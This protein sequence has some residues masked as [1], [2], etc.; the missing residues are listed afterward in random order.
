MS[1]YT[2]IVLDD[3]ELG[4]YE[5]NPQVQNKRTFEAIHQSSA[6]YRSKQLFI[7]SYP[8]SG[9]ARPVGAEDPF[10]QSSMPAPPAPRSPPGFCSLHILF[11]A[12]VFCGLG[13]GPYCK[14]FLCVLCVILAQAE[15]RIGPE[16]AC[17]YEPRGRFTAGGFTGSF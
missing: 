16:F 17:C 9:I 12:F 6:P 15:S 14:M 10:A 13:L 1:I 7:G 4:E 2:Q 11:Q 5:L 8:T 3:G